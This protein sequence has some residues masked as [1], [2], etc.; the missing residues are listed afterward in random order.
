MSL[1]KGFVAGIAM[2]LAAHASANEKI[3]YQHW[4]VDIGAHTVEAHTA[5]VN[6]TTFGVFCS[7]DQCLFYLHQNFQ[8][9]PGTKYSV[10][11]SSQTVANALSMECTQIGGNLFQILDPFKTILRA[12]QGGGTIGFALAL[13]SGDFAVTRFSLAGAKQAID[14]ALLE[15]TKT[16]EKSPKGAPQNVP[17]AKI[18]DQLI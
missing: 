5:N 8:C 15:A 12:V 1:I 17:P 18:K 10:L 7:G 3:A 2:A 13:Q 14:R 9:T 6:K 4:L 11:M 16:K